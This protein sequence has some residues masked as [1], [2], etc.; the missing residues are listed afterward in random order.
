MLDVQYVL[1]I[2][3][4]TCLSSIIYPLILHS[5]GCCNL[6]LISIFIY[7]YFFETHITQV[8]G[9]TLNQIN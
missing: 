9:Y 2:Y 1:V 3:Y 6:L 4:Y 5:L 7:F 8:Y